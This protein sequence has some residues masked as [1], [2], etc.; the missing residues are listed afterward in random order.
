MALVAGLVVWST[1]SGVPATPPA[2]APAS[3]PAAWALDLTGHWKGQIA[4]TIPDMPPRPALREVSLD[5]DRAGGIVGASVVLTDPGHGGAGAGY[6]TVPDGRRRVREL[7]EALAAAPRGAAVSLDF[8]PLPPWVPRRDRLWRA[9][10][11]QRR[12]PDEATYLLVE[13]LESDYL[14]QAGVNSSGFLSYIFLSPNYAAGRGSDALSKVIH[15]DPDS[16]LRGFRNIVWDLSGAA[17]FVTL[18]V[19]ATISAPAGRPDRLVLRRN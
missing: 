6:L 10:E 19:H 15:P 3:T 12:N 5:T 11:G 16:A 18:Q 8:I 4:T 17:D 1:R 7:A 2:P 13:S 14:L 9:I